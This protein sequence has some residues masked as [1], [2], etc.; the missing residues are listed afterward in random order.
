MS[1]DLILRL[2]T[3]LKQCHSRKVISYY[4]KSKKLVQVPYLMNIMISCRHWS[5]NI[6]Y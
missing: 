5:V 3:N 4:R 6:N 2:D 1:F